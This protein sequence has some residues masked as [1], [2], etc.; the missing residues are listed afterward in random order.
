M[1]SWRER[2][3]DSTIPLWRRVLLSIVA[4]IIAFGM[5]HR[6]L[7]SALVTRGDDLMY[8]GDLRRAL[9]FYRRA[10]TFDGDSAAAADRY[11]FTAFLTADPHLLRKAIS[12]ARRFLL[13]RRSAAVRFDT[14]LCE[15]RLHL[16]EAAEVDFAAAARDTKNAQA[17]V[18]AGYAALAGSHLR[19]AR[20]WWR[21][22]LFV[23]PN[24]RP[25]E[26][27]LERR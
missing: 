21:R 24:Y 22:A 20:E 14:A 15:R 19:R 8:R 12:V 18:L 13:R 7:A 17:Y 9:T 4:S 16:N 26:R 2:G 3:R 23:R 6:E 27:A 11:A 1:H 10:L 25:A 5:M